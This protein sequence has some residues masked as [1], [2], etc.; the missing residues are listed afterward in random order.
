VTK[1]ASMRPAVTQVAARTASESYISI[2]TDAE[3]TTML[4]CGHFVAFPVSSRVLR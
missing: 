3:Q 4:F 1:G 2:S